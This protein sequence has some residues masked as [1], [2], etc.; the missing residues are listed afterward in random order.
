MEKAWSK[1]S[2]ICKFAD[3]GE[4]PSIMNQT[5]SVN[6][7]RTKNL[8]RGTLVYNAP[9]AL[10]ISDKAISYSLEEPK[11]CYIWSLGMLL[12]LLINSDLEYS[13]S[14]ELD[15]C[16]FESFSEAKDEVQKLMEHRNQCTQQ[17]L[18]SFV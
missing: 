7:T 11:R 15:D 14:P 12:F 1:E 6:H 9:Q 3:F 5:D 18:V 13:Y 16:G 8:E 4:S 10:L 2:I 17:N